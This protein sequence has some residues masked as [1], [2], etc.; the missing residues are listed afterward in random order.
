[1]TLS[2]LSSRD[3]DSNIKFTLSFN[4]SNGPPSAIWCRY[5]NN[6]EVIFTRDPLP[7]VVRE[8]IRS[9]YD[10]NSQPDMTRV[11]VT[12]TAPRVERTYTC[13]VTVEGRSIFSVGTNFDPKGT[14]TS[15]ASITGKCV[16]C[17]TAVLDCT[18]HY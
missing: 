16:Q 13:T 3:D 9:H 1:M 4:V 18:A 5:G 17:V 12:L 11:I 8:V 6:I 2:L 7:N 10:S 15:T 14:G